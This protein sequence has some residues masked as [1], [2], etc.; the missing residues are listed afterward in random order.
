MYTLSWDKSMEAI[1]N[2]IK[3]EKIS[4]TLLIFVLMGAWYA[5]GWA[6]DEFVKRDDFDRLTAMITEH[7]EDMRIV[8]A[9]QIVRDKEVLLQVALHAA[10]QDPSKKNEIGHI[11]REIDQAKAYRQCLIEKR[12]NCK[13]LKPPQ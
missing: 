8:T 7:V 3:N 13:H 1:L 10:D 12:P 5:H 2:L 6:N 4:G 11:E 9:S